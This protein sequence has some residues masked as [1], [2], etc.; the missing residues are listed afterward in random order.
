LW[1]SRREQIPIIEWLDMKTIFVP[2]ILLVLHISASASFAQT[3]TTRWN[4]A[5][6]IPESG[7]GEGNVYFADS[8][9][10]YFVGYRPSQGVFAPPYSSFVFYNTSDAGSSWRN[11]D[12]Y[13]IYGSDTSWYGEAAGGMGVSFAARPVPGSIAFTN[14]GGQATPNHDSLTYYRS[15]DF[16]VS[17][18]HKRTNPHLARGVY[19]VESIPNEKNVVLMKGTDLSLLGNSGKL[20]YSTDAGVSFIDI[21]WDSTLLY[22]ISLAGFGTTGKFNQVNNHTFGMLDDTTWI[23]CVADSNN[24]N[25]SSFAVPYSNVTLVS[26]DAGKHWTAN[27]C[28]LPKLPSNQQSPAANL[29]CL[30]GTST[31]YLV[32]G[33]VEGGDALMTGQISLGFPLFGVNFF[34]S[35][36]FGKTWGIDTSFKT[37]RRGYEAVAPGEFWCT[38]T[39]HDSVTDKS[40]AR[41]IAHTLDNGKSWAIDST[42]LSNDNIYDGRTVTFS[43]RAHGWIVAQ[44]IDRHEIA[45]FRYVDGQLDVPTTPTNERTI[46]DYQVNP[47]PVNSTTTIHLQAGAIVEAVVVVDLLGREYDCPFRFSQ[48]GASV[49]IQ[50]GSLPSGTYFARVSSSNSVVSVPLIVRH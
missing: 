28:I 1:F 40:A 4:L 18:F 12:W 35:S 9:H 3:S 15:T 41:W 16:G 34:Y 39:A 13:E 47:N 49:E 20:F 6:T 21:R 37:N 30:K 48:G 5:G 19:T 25:T 29:F 38:I 42:S 10:G 11:V 43:D 23:I 45:I 14:A 2:I 31:I 8:V 50:C 7:I 27:R 26:H 36:D 22:N 46:A 17:W 32:T 24:A 44:P 33:Y